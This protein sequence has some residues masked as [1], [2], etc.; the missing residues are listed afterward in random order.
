MNR[1]LEAYRARRNK[2]SADIKAPDGFTLGGLR[3]VRKD[4]TILFSRGWW[5]VP[6][7]WIGEKVWVH[8][9]DCYG[10]EIEVAP[11]GIHIYC[12][13][14]DHR[15]KVIRPKRVEKSEP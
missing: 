15:E 5:K 8:V 10:I 13:L 7:E 14:L 3:L 12:A 1:I 4:G 2:P 11:P 6:D 9:A